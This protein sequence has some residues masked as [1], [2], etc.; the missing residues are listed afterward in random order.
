M[1]KD[2]ANPLRRVL[3]LILE[4]AKEMVRD[5][6][7]KIVDGV[8]VFREDVKQML[9]DR[10]ARAHSHCTESDP[11]GGVFNA[12]VRARRGQTRSM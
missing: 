7:M 9:A 11:C 3:D 8:P 6:R 10:E 12:R 5:G 2:P 4:N 1:L